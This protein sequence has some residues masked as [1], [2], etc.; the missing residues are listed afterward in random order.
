VLEP[1]IDGLKDPE[2]R[3]RQVAGDALIRWNSPAVARRL[4]ESLTS[5]ALRRP[6]SELLARMGTSAVDPLVD[7]LREGHPELAATVG[8]TLERLV[9]RDVFLQRL[10]SMDPADRLGAVEALG[11]LG[12]PE[13][14]EGLTRALSD[15]NENI[16]ITALRAL[17]D[18]GDRS[19]IDAVQRSA[20]G[21]PLP[22]VAAA[23][24]EA[25]RKL[26]S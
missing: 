24:E 19:A 6:A 12:G 13:A 14:V 3:V 16:R 22:E 10:G 2:E 26:Q 5:P 1:L 18:L 15:P 17:G 21:D 8:V 7:L 20:E 4:V 23:A 11:A 25:L 9:G